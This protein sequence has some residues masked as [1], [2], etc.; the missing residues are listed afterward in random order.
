MQKLLRSL[1][2]ICIGCCCFL[3][4][5]MPLLFHRPTSIKTLNIFTWGDFFPEEI[6]QKFTQI[7]HIK[8]NV[9]YY[10]SNEELIAKLEKTGGRGYDIIFPSDYAIPI[11]QK[12]NLL[13][14][15]DKNHLY[16]LAHLDP[17]LLNHS[18]DPGNQ[19]S[20]PYA[21]EVYGFLHNSPRT[22][23]WKNL[24]EDQL[25]IVMV[26]DPI[27]AI[28]FTIH[29]LYG[30]NTILSNE[31]KKQIIHTLRDQKKRVKAYTNYMSHHFLS[32]HTPFLSIIR[33]SSFFKNI[34]Q[35]QRHPNA[36]FELP[37]GPVFISIENVAI[38]KE[39]AFLDAAYK[40]IN[41]IY[42]PEIM[43][44][45]INAFPL[46]P[47]IPYCL[48]WSNISSLDEYCQL[49]HTMQFHSYIFFNSRSLSEE[50]VKKLWIMIKS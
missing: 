16:F 29:Y 27:E 21:W 32:S 2:V 3:S 42:Q 8:L 1:F 49:L 22:P 46:F 5:Y 10:A 4:A 38:S 44:K 35:I 48:K 31:Q 33:S 28:C 36:K 37:K 45:Q 18:F 40:F 26:E 11:L 12:K 50:E 25:F 43:A 41:L 30:H 20:L 17:L 19:F 24:F 14:P 15:L 23:S 34:H 6:F 39:C 7:H 9:T 13:A 47:S